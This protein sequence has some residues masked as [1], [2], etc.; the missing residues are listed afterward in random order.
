[1]GPARAVAE[2]RS[3]SDLLAQGRVEAAL[4]GFAAAL[5]YDNRNV[6]AR[7]ALAVLL[8][9][10]QRGAEAQAVLREGIEAVPSNTS[11]PLL[12]ARLQV[13]GGDVRG[14][15]ETLER[16]LP[17]ARGQPEYHAFLATLMQMQG[18]HADA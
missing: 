5:R 14:A 12:L 1:T 16:S 13:E 11:W 17:Q 6:P 2:Y 7:Q 15:L 10:N 8:L 4:S 18:R 9:D 3:A